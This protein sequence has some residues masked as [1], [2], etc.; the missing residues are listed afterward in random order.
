MS[1]VM[2]LW[3]WVRLGPWYL[4]MYPASV[5]SLS[6]IGRTLP[7]RV[8]DL[9]SGRLDDRSG[10]RMRRSI[11]EPRRRIGW[12][13]RGKWVSAARSWTNLVSSKYLEPVSV[14]KWRES[15]K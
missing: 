13:F 9:C 10:L 11:N 15:R 12:G 2:L 7:Q 6:G 8:G 1:A 5:P 3:P 4:K 14:E